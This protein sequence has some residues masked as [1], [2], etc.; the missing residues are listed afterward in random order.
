MATGLPSTRPRRQAGS[1]G[2]SQ[3]R[4]R[5][6]GKTFDCAIEQVRLGEPPLRDQPDVFGNI[7]VRR[8]SPLAVDD[9]VVVARI[10]DIRWLHRLLRR[11]VNPGHTNGVWVVR[12]RLFVSP[13]LPQDIPRYA[14]PRHEMSI[15][16]RTLVFANR[17]SFRLYL[18]GGLS[19]PP[20]TG[21][22]RRASP[23]RALPAR[24][25]QP[26]SLVSRWCSSRNPNLTSRW[27]VHNP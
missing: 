13:G 9:L 11:A 20:S 14:D 10:G 12:P 19:R 23:H 25:S 8:T 15:D 17:C 7:G 16:S 6:P 18:G 5:M 27:I 21:R 2:R 1:H 22:A 26:D 3:V 24:V 4:P